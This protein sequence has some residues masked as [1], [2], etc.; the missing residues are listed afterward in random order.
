MGT[1]ITA[2]HQATCYFPFPLLVF[3][4]EKEERVPFF[5][6]LRKYNVYLLFILR[7]SFLIEQNVNLLPLKEAVLWRHVEIRKKKK[8]VLSPARHK[9]VKK[10]P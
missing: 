5:N 8:R 9:D 6:V 10:L 7:I 1:Y 3:P 4:S 2:Q